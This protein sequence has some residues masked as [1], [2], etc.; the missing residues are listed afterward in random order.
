VH[1]GARGSAAMLEHFADLANAK[2]M[3]GDAFAAALD[4][5]N[6]YIKMKAMLPQK[7][8]QQVPQAQKVQNQPNKQNQGGF[9]PNAFPKVQ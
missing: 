7:Q 8:A 2:Q 9:N 6:K 4:T 1:V 5:E 3:S